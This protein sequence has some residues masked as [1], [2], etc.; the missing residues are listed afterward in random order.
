MKI[1]FVG[2]KG[3]PAKYG[4]VER[5]VEALASRLAERG[6]EVL[7]FSRHN[8]NT[9]R[10]EYKGM[11]I[12]SS[13]AIPEKH[14][15]MISHTLLSLLSLVGKHIDV[16]HIHS[17]D[18]ALLSFIPRIDTKV[19]V[20]SHGQAYRREKWGPIAKIFS[21]LAERSFVRFPHKRIAVSKTLKKYYEEKYSCEIIYIP[22]GVD[23]ERVEDTSA[24]VK[25]GLSPDDYLLFVGRLIPTKG[26][27]TLINAF[28][29][30]RTDKKLVIV[31]GSSYSEE[32]SMKLKKRAH[33]KI[34]FLGYR[35]GNELAQLYSHAYCCVVPSE[36][37]GLA[38][39][40][41]DAMGYGMCVIYSDIPEN[42]EAAHGV[43]IQFRN[44]DSDDLADKIKFA[45][46]NPSYC[47]EIGLKARERV[48]KEYNWDTIAAQ[49]ESVYNSLFT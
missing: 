15:E 23:I 33:E 18:P 39:T 48:Q 40:L 16:I 41:L 1:A 10:G 45:L 38:I 36:V 5:H 9:L 34:M 19:V 26:C 12:V 46:N 28:N 47:E 30:T 3:V 35:Y 4:G 13:A 11:N 42:Y 43:G 37:E 27:N 32:F 22:N 6:H 2:Q 20:T 31:G 24:I 44:R 8:Y 21:R 7:V 29:K 25:L 17:T 14:T 49:T